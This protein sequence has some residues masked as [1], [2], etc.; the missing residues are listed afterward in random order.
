MNKSQLEKVLHDEIPITGLMGIE[1]QNISENS[2]TLGAPIEKN[3]NHKRTA[4]GGSLYS[5]CVLTGWSLLFVKLKQLGAHGHI[6]I[7]E[8]NIQ[9]LLPVTSNIT[10]F[11]EVEDT[12]AFDRALKLFMKKGRARFELRTT[13]YQDQS[14]AVVFN[15]KYVIHV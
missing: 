14:L 7:Q 15:G 3:I 10:A 9:Y 12:K 8:S 6:V 11:S 4:F 5:V 1:V 2:V 13:V